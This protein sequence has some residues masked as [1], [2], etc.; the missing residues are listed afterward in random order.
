M[1][2]KA[3][4]FV[5]ADFDF[6]LLRSGLSEQMV[7]Q[8]ALCCCFERNDCET[9][10]S[11]FIDAADMQKVVMMALDEDLKLPEDRLRK[12]AA[13]FYKMNVSKEAPVFIKYMRRSRLNQQLELINA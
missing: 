2:L 12:A 13:E 3:I 9:R 5:H 10:I 7:P 11:L 8:A 4:P 6:D 1:N